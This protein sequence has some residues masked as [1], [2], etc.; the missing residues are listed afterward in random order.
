MQTDFDDIRFTSSSDGVTQLNHWRASYTPS[1]SAVFWVN[2]PTV[3]A[4]SSTIYIYYG[5]S[6]VSSASNGISTFVLF[7]DFED[8]NMNGWS[9][10]SSIGYPE[11]VSNYKYD[12]SYSVRFYEGVNEVEGDYTGI[13]RND[14]DLAGKAIDFYHFSPDDTYSYYKCLYFHDN[15]EIRCDYDA[16][17]WYHTI[18][19]GQT[20]TWLHLRQYAI[21]D[22]NNPWFIYVDRIIV[23]KYSSPEP[24]AGIGSEETH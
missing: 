21:E 9:S 14:I 13:T 7:D 20:G 11:V 15:L 18:I 17:T 1:S 3:S 24:S 6:S 16:S 23:R 8:G 12:G 4:G 10:E 5:N 2:V 22:G 19:T